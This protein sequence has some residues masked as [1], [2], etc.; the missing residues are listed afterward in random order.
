MAMKHAFRAE[1]VDTAISN[2]RRAARALVKSEIVAVCGV[3]IDVPDGCAI[4]G[5]W[6]KHAHFGRRDV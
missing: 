3:V 1:G 5:V 4:V 2:S 6:L